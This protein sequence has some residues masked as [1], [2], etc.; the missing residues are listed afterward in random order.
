L[1][2]FYLV[3][4]A[5]TPG[6]FGSTIVSGY[7]TSDLIEVKP[8]EN[9]DYYI[10]FGNTMN[11]TFD[12]VRFYDENN[13]L[14]H[15]ITGN[16][17]ERPKVAGVKYRIDF[18]VGTKYLRFVK[19]AATLSG[20]YTAS[21]KDKGYILIVGTSITRG[22]GSPDFLNYPEY[23]AAKLGYGIFNES[24]SSSK[25][26]WDP[27]PYTGPYLGHEGLCLSA[28]VAEMETKWRPKVIDGSITESQ[29]NIW[30]DSS[31]ERRILPFLN[32]STIFIFDHGFNDKEKILEQFNA[33]ESSIDWDDDDRGNFTG[34]M[35]YIF[36]EILKRKPFMKIV[37]GGYFENA[38]NVE[39]RHAT[40]ITSVLTWAA[41]HYNYPLLDVW[42][43][44]GIGANYVP[45][46]SN[47]IANYN[48]THGTSYTKWRPDADGNIM[49]FQM[50]CPDKTHPYTEEAAKRLNPI[51]AALLEKAGA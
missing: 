12:L 37:I 47:Y 25:I 30:K 24:I 21:G 29:L 15:R 33:G 39:D 41:R 14:I 32:D 45:N 3:G 43:Y 27:N 16:S 40:A 10:S 22:P 20:L 8:N 51:F 49:Q 13:V 19:W 48:A 17:T 31:Y 23:A 28:T 1:P 36:N 7:E 50:F 34:A 11:E 18:P 6:I 5:F 2:E 44:A 46:S 4:T 42:N 9:V 38:I 35:R 26:Y